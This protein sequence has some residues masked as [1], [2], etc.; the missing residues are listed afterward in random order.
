MT[1]VEPIP[2]IPSRADDLPEPL[3]PA[4]RPR[5]AYWD[6]ADCCW[7]TSGGAAEIPTPRDGD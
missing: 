3:R 5:T 4:P 7:R 6:A 1:A 2:A